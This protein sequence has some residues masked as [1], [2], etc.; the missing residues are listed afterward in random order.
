MRMR[1]VRSTT[2]RTPRIYLGL[3]LAYVGFVIYGSL[4][5]LRFEYLP[6]D[7]L[8]ERLRIIVLGPVSLSRSDLL[9]NVVLFVPITF[10]GLGWLSFGK[11]R[12]GWAVAVGVTLAAWL[13]SVMVEFSQLYF[14]ERT[15]SRNDIAA[16]WLGAVIGVMTWLAFGDRLERWVGRVWRDPVQHRPAVDILCGYL[17][18]LTFYQLIPFDMSLSLGEAAVKWRMGRINLVPLA[19]A[20]ALDPYIATVKAALMVPAGFLFALITRRRAYLLS[21]VIVQ[22][23]LFA[24]IVEL[25]QFFEFHR[26]ASSTDV[27]LGVVGAGVGGCLADRFGPTARFPAVETRFWQRH[28]QAIVVAVAAVWIVLLSWQRWYP[29]DFTWPEAGLLEG[30][31]ANLRVPFFYLSERPSRVLTIEQVFRE[32]WQ[33][34]PLG[35]VLAGVIR[36]TG[37]TVSIVVCAGIAVGLEFGQLFVPERIPDISTIIVAVAGGTVGV[38]VSPGFMR[39]FLTRPDSAMAVDVIGCGTQIVH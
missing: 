35:L 34:F 25:L 31:G 36:R 12:R 9:T 28:G 1:P 38:V 3:L 14:P 30:V 15:A 5:P 29:F 11:V 20:A 32:F 7:E 22:G 2:S 37:R 13:F 23:F 4:V 27:I 8:W 24:G 39:M 19:D 6:I 17:L 33:F 10:L 26:Y 18:V 21:M 16:Q